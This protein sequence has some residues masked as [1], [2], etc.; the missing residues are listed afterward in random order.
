[1]CLEPVGRSVI[2]EELEFSNT[3]SVVLVSLDTPVTRFV[4]ISFRG[5]GMQIFTAHGAPT[6]AAILGDTV[7]QE[8]QT[9]PHSPHALLFLSTTQIP[10][11]N[12]CIIFT[13]SLAVCGQN[14][15][16]TA[17]SG[18]KPFQIPRGI[19]LD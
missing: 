2:V 3:I 6:L 7:F 4:F 11:C 5:L 14:R 12:S 17:L 1:M 9:P 18:G 10:R 13:N 16:T 19:R 8:C 15:V